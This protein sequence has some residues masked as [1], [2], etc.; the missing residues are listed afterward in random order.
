MTEI[1]PF[2]FPATGQPVRTVMVDG[3]PWFVAAD[4]CAVLD[5]GNPRSS[6]ALLDEDERGVYRVDTPGGPQVVTIINEPGLYSLILRS[7]KP[8]AKAFK[9]WI[10][11][12]VLPAIR[13]TGS[14]GAPRW[15]LPETFAEALELAAQ[16]TRALEAAQAEADELRG[17]AHSWNVLASGEGD[18]S[19]ADAAK[20][21]T[22]DPSIDTGR[23][24]L[25]ALLYELGWVYRQQADGRHRAYQRHVDNGRLS[26]LP[27][28]YENPKT[29]EL[30]L[31]APQVRV[32]P[33]G[34][35]ELHK[36]L[37][38]TADLDLSEVNA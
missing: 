32:K 23:G 25:F 22:R 9:R 29:G 21:L 34:L 12:E 36:R 35:R 38:G 4:V 20:I 13:Q 31:G 26:E 5:L 30:T 10:V 15:V 28:Q 19:V 6:L 11:H 16:Q 14:Y 3:R 33:K 17:P 37:G 24:R 18:Y 27:Q 7:R 2:A 8:E 1:T